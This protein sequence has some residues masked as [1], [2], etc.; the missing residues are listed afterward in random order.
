MPVQNRRLDRRLDPTLYML[1][2]RQMAA[3]CQNSPPVIFMVMVF[4]VPLIDHLCFWKFQES[5]E[6]ANPIMQIIF[7]RTVQAA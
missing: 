4:S 7:T 1:C 5:L 2:A 3:P 6:I